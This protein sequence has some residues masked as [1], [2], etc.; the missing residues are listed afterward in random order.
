MK[1]DSVKNITIFLIP[2]VI[3]LILFFAYYPGV[4]TY[5]SYNQWQQVQSGLISNAHPFFT[6]FFMLILSKIYNSPSTILIYQI[7]IFSL[8]WSY[9]CNYTR[10]NK[11]DFIIKII[12]TILLSL[13]P[14]ISIYSITLWKDILYSYYLIGISFI[15]YII[16]KK[17][18]KYNKFE[19][20]LLSL[21][22]F[23]VFNYRHNGMIVAVLLLIF[24]M[25]LIKRKSK[26]HKTGIVILSCFI[27]LNVFIMVPK[28]LYLSKT[29]ENTVDKNISTIDNYM[30][31]MYA[32]HLKDNNITSKEDLEFLNNIT[33]IE[34]LASKYNP[35]LIN[36]TN[37]L[38][39][40]NEFIIENNSKYRNLFIET[41]LKH[42]I[43]I[44]RHYLKANAL[45]LSPYKQGYVYV[46]NFSK[47]DPP[48]DFDVESKFPIIKN[49][50]N[51]VITLTFYEPINTIF[52][53]PA[54]LMYLSI[55][56]TIL[57][58]VILKNKKIYIVLLPM[59]AN[60]ISLLPI[61]LAQDLRYVYINYLTFFFVLLLVVLNYKTIFSYFKKICSRKEVK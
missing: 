5:D 45:L 22:L 1:K 47:W 9:I 6:T 29:E 15:F 28:N 34:I 57:L 23:L 38:E 46:Y 40:D 3:L 11:K 49:T 41:T 25:I 27:G 18:F 32:A 52:H 16:I 55:I 44:F 59:I 51:R 13:I 10:K 4:L 43:T 20:I 50:Y 58:A 39:R 54:N 60:T 17:D 30:F 14:I 31:W 26:K 12:F 53:R 61:N 21:L 2:F 24:I 7:F 48:Y 35:Y 42:P 56:L 33:N 36:D 8:L 19:I 37:T